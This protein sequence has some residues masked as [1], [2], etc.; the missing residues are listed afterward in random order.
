[1]RNCIW[2]WFD[3]E[4]VVYCDNNEDYHRLVKWRGARHRSTYFLPDG[5]K[6]Y[7]AIIHRNVV[8]RAAKMLDLPIRVRDQAKSS[9]SPPQVIDTQGGSKPEIAPQRRLID[10]GMDRRVELSDSSSKSATRD[11][12]CWVYGGF[13][14]PLKDMG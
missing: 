1:M 5:T 12:H 6:R 9:F 4:F 7:D 2:E 11:W 13:R 3:D 10:D 14:N 8:N